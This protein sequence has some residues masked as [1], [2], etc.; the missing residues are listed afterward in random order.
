[1]R[2]Q[3]HKHQHRAFHASGFGGFTFLLALCSTPNRQAPG[4]RTAV[5]LMPSSWGLT[6]RDEGVKKRDEVRASACARFHSSALNW[7]K[8]FSTSM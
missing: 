2:H 5:L 3:A 4:F 7:S 1:M 6:L 8:Y